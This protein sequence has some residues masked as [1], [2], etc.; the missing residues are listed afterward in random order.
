MC[1]RAC[2]R[3]CVQQQEIERLT[4]QQSLNMDNYRHIKD[5]CDTLR[6]QLGDMETAHR[7]LMTQI[8][9]NS[10]TMAE[11]HTEVQRHQTNY[12]E[13]QRYGGSDV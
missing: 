13:A 7:S 12:L 4:T 1:V 2:V 9:E 8:E 5:E 3:A 6:K 11:H 10:K